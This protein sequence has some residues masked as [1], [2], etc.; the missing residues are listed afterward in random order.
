MQSPSADPQNIGYRQLHVGA[1]VVD[2]DVVLVVVLVV[3]VVLKQSP[4]QE[5]YG[6][7]GLLMLSK[8]PSVLANMH[9]PLNL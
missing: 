3:V 9:G 1:D 6:S 7:H 8:H 2:V 4:P 5:K